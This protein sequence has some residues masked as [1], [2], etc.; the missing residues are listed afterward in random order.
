MF[1]SEKLVLGGPQLYL[2]VGK[3]FED[4]KDVE[5][6]LTSWAGVGVESGGC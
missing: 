5:K 1:K 4:A 3:Q 6:V 2:I